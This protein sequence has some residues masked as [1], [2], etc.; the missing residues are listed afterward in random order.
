VFHCQSLSADHGLLE[1]LAGLRK[2]TYVD[3]LYLAGASD[4]ISYLQMLDDVFGSVLV[5]GHNPGLADLA[6]SFGRA[7]HIKQSDKD[8][9]VAFSP[10][11]FVC[12]SAK[13]ASWK[14]ITPPLIRLTHCVSV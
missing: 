7:E 9:L 5:V 10:A 11:T 12:A 4:I 13:V 14:D 8:A 3:A 6:R 1:L 2:P